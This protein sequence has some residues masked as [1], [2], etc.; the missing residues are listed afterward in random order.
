MLEGKFTNLRALEEED[1]ETLK[2]WR[3]AKHVKKTTREYLLLNMFNQKTW[4]TSTSKNNPPREIMFGITNKK[5][6]LLGVCGL[7][8]IDWKNRNS[9]IS[10]YLSQPHWQKTKEIR[11][12]LDILI[13]YAFDELA[14]HRLWV[15]IY[16]IADET[17]DLFKKV[18]FIQEG[19][20]RDTL[21]RDGK[22]WN[23]Y[24]YSKINS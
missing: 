12:V 7:T 14:L 5:N 19:I 22:W 23:S 18:N 24:L 2:H 8:Y 6:K 17:I 10:L 3:N 9:E 4:F 1:L 21:W 11:D 15:E 16:G 20:L 13:K